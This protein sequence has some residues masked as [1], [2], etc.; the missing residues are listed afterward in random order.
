MIIGKWFV[1]IKLQIE[2]I[3]ILACY[4]IE[5]LV[6]DSEHDAYYEMKTAQFLF[7]LSATYYMENEVYYKNIV[8][9]NMGSS[10]SFE[11]YRNGSIIK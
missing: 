3:R 9:N 6:L 4:L 1:E 5:L 8:V 10:F 7:P 11:L 2:Y